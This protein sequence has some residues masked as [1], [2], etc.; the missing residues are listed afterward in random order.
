MMVYRKEYYLEEQEPPTEGSSKRVRFDKEM[1]RWRNKAQIIV[2]KRRRGK[3]MVKIELGWD[4]ATTSFYD[5]DS[6]ELPWNQ[7][8]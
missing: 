2:P 3:R 8:G 4:G 1:E 5:L 7:W 6:G